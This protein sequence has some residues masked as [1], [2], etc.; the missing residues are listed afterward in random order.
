MIRSLRSPLRY[1][2]RSALALSLAC[3]SLGG[4]AAMAGASQQSQA[5]DVGLAF[6]TIG[7]L[8]GLS[9]AALGLAAKHW[10]NPTA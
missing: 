8:I 7:L 1:T 6:G 9:S 3:L 4:L 10:Q 2:L 5:G